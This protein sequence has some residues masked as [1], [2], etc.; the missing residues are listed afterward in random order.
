MRIEPFSYDFPDALCALPDID[1]ETFHS[2]D[3]T[4][5]DIAISIC[6]MCKHGE[7]GDDTCFQV[8][9]ELDQQMGHAWGIWGGRT[10]RE[11]QI[12]LDEEDGASGV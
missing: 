5:Q 6:S 1:P 11:R 3:L 2:D 7:N 12:L 8:G 4:L 9:L 10:A